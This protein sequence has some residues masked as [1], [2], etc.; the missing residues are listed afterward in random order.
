MEE[1]KQKEI[2]YYDKKAESVLEEQSGERVFGDFEGFKPQDLSSFRFFYK[3][4]GK[5]CNDKLVLDYGCGNGVHSAI[6]LEAGAKKVIAIDLSE[7]S[8]EI[9]KNRLK[10]EVLERK[11]EF[12]KMDCENTEFPDNYFDLV[13]DAGTFS[14]LDLNKVF[15][16]LKRILKPGGILIGIETF[17]HNP[18]ANLK[19]SFNKLFGKR[20]SWAAEHIF[21]E[22]DIEEAR[23]YF[24]G[25]ETYFFHPISFLTI[26][27]LSFPGG[28]ALLKIFELLDKIILALPFLKK[29]SFKVVFV[30]KNPTKNA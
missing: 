20:T 10:G 19:R 8:L 23:K 22:K 1:R 14:S 12:K 3:L 29:Y 11:I 9:A 21:Q 6:P 30:F 4:L 7:K 24:S 26:P 17:G 2:E 15:P 5:Y 18:L 13:M 25:I 27:F 28:K 16:E